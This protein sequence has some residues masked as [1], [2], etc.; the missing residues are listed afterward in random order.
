MQR[1][2]TRSSDLLTCPELLKAELEQVLSL[3]DPNTELD[4]SPALLDV[5]GLQCQPRS[6]DDASRSGSMEANNSHMATG[7][8]A[9]SLGEEGPS[10]SHTHVPHALIGSSMTIALSP[11]ALPLA[12][13]KAASASRAAAVPETTRRAQHVSHS[14]V[15][16][17]RRDRCV[18]FHGRSS[19][20]HG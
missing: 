10:S 19:Q 14:T 16:K 17:Q 3:I 9:A 7:P 8:A 12:A 15:E 6:P 13:A 2:S 18:Q 5:T 11:P 4:C 20:S 1:S